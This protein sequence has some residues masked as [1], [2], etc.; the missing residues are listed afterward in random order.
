MDRLYE[1]PKKYTERVVATA[2][3]NVPAEIEYRDA[4]GEVVGYWAYGHW[5]PCY[6][7][8]GEE[9]MEI[10]DLSYTS[11]TNPPD[12]AAIMIIPSGWK[13]HYHVI[14]EDPE[15][16]DYNYSHEFMHSD[17]V[18]LRY[19]ISPMVIRQIRIQDND[20]EKEK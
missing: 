17:E 7:Y 16:G 11:I 4:N 19:N 15:E 9:I 12:P 6:P 8:K 14:T 3:D 20:F 18:A 1:V 5:A 13:D 10:T 2:G